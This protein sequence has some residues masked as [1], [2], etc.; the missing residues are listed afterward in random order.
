M[1]VSR[2]L[3]GVPGVSD[4]RR[5]EIVKLAK[6]MRYVPNS[7]ARS[8]VGEQ[9]AL[10][11]ISL[12]TLFNDVFADILDGMRG[13]F[14]AAGFTTVVNTTEYSLS[15]ERDWVNSL[16]TWRPTAMVLTGV[17]HHPSVVELLR[18]ASVP[19][20]ELW[21]FSKEP[22]DISVGVDHEK[23]GFNIAFE[24]KKRGYRRPAFVGLSSGH[25]PRAEKRLLGVQRAFSDNAACEVTVV[26]PEADSPYQIGYKGLKQIWNHGESK[27]DVI[28][29]LSDL[30][31]V[32]ALMA[33]DELSIN[34]PGNLGIVGFNGLP[35]TRVLPKKLTTVITPRRR[36]GTLG[37]SCLIA[38]ING[39]KSDLSSELETQIVL[40]DTTR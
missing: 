24:L 9:S 8:L 26:R 30:L 38:R 6:R 40:G 4:T 17:N 37:A 28:F 1:T 18:E 23:A 15:S 11:G 14:D 20:L 35:I 22:V 2:A 16:L 13:A 5:Q 36:M 32:G 34:V 7:N 33:C 19:T 10:I 29:F 3:R 31:A 39:V 12:P 25:D 27:A 21:D